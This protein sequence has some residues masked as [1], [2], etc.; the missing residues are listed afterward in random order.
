MANQI[1]GHGFGLAEDGVGT[2]VDG[3]VEEVPEAG[4][5]ELGCGGFQPA[6]DAGFCGEQ[7]AHD[8]EELADV[9]VGADDQVGLY[10]ANEAYQ[11]KSGVPGTR[12]AE[13]MECEVRRQW[14]GGWPFLGKNAEMDIKQSW[15][16]VLED[17][18][19]YLNSPAAGE[20]LRE[21]EQAGLVHRSRGIQGEG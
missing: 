10:G 2:A 19:K 5:R 7:G 4:A 12:Y 9:G 15:I 11:R 20:E 17:A 18:E 8:E 21:Y 3:G 1:I 16:E 14:A 13:P 6:N